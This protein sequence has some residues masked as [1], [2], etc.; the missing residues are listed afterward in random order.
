MINLSMEYLTEVVCVH[1]C[2]H[3]HMAHGWH[4]TVKKPFCILKVSITQKR[5]NIML[6][7]LQQAEAKV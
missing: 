5:R 7:S 2:M 1:T 4:F 3:T 6:T